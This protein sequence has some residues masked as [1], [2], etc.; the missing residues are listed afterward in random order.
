[1]TFNPFDKRIEE[2]TAEDTHLLVNRKVAEGHWVEYKSDFPSTLKIARSIAS[3]ANSYVG[4]YFVGVEANKKTSVAISIPGFS[5]SQYPDPI[6]TV[7][8]SIK[9]SVQPK[10]LFT[11]RLLNISEARAVLIAYVPDNQL[12]PFVTKDGRIYR[13]IGESSDPV[14]END[15]HAIDQLVSRGKAPLEVFRAFCLDERTR[16]QAEGEDWMSIYLMQRMPSPVKPP[17]AFFQTSNLSELLKTAKETV[18]VEL[19]DSEFITATIPFDT[20]MV[21]ERSVVLRQVEN[22]EVASNVLEMELFKNGAAKLHIPFI[23]L[24]IFPPINKYDFKSDKAR[25]LLQR[26]AHKDDSIMYLTYFDVRNMWLSASILISFYVQWLKRT[27]G[28]SIVED[29]PCWAALSL[30]GS[31]RHVP[32]VDGDVW[33]EYVEKYGI[34]IIF[35]DSILVPDDLTDVNRISITHDSPLWASL[36]AKAALSL[37]LPFDILSKIVL[38]TND[39]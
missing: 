36:A 33:V 26:L 3:F 38:S 17:D 15:R 7:Q 21:S 29:F 10:P 20:V 28:E 16:S 13:R 11:L 14:P 24:Q 35:R 8:E 9:T 32:F 5:L 6:S 37:G 27:F 25:V 31:W 1:M 12:C 39:R 23:N 4:W 34:P 19:D 18:S 22:K 30:K 2:V